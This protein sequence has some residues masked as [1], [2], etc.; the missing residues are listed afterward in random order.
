M[1]A[2]WLDYFKANESK[3]SKCKTHNYTFNLLQLT[4]VGP[5]ET[6][7]HIPDITTKDGLLD[8]IMVGNILEFSDALDT[9]CFGKNVP[10]DIME[11]RS[12][13]RS[14]Y[15]QFQCWFIRWYILDIEGEAVNPCYVFQLSLIDFGVAL[16]SYGERWKMEVPSKQLRRAVLSFFRTNFQ[17]LLGA[18]EERLGKDIAHC[19]WLSWTGP[20]FGIYRRDDRQAWKES[21]DWAINPIYWEI[22]EDTDDEGVIENSEGSGDKEEE[23]FL[24]ARE[25]LRRSKR[26]AFGKLLFRIYSGIL[27]E[28]QINPR[29]R[30]Q[31]SLRVRLHDK[32]DIC[33]HILEYQKKHLFRL[34][35]P[36]NKIVHAIENL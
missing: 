14:R 19:H 3:S 33:F 10:D 2:A 34:Y 6:S 28:K 27:T 25:L 29:E 32:Y 5:G 17:D 13:A 12:A 26:I 1:M 18:L 23:V 16:C 4:V 22:Y 15:R 11:E 7:V 8:V 24:E 30:V 35:F 31:R 21:E 36:L 9:D 20:H